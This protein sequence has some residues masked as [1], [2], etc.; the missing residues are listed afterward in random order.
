MA[1]VDAVL[2][3]V[4]G[5]GCALGY[6][7]ATAGTLGKTDVYAAASVLVAINFVLLTT[8]QHGYRLKNI[9]NLPRTFRMTLT[10]WTGLFGALLAIAFTMKVS[11]EFSRGTTISFYLVGLTALLA[12]KTAAAR[13]TAHGLR[14]GAFANGRALLIAEFGLA[15]SS[16]AVEELGQHGYRL[17]RVLEIPPKEPRLAA[18]AVVAGLAL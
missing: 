7:I 9:T 4:S 16:N 2:V 11:D 18:A 10:T 8:V 13:W 5:I 3:V 6:H 17:M 15:T 12:W 1:V 14:T